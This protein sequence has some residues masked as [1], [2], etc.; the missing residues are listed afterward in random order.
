[1]RK[2]SA[3]IIY[4]ISQNPI[5]GAVI[6]INDEGVILEVLNDN[7]GLMDVEFFPGII[8]PGFINVHCHLELSHLKGLIEEKQGIVDF[9]LTVQKLR[10]LPIEEIEAAMLIA[11]QSMYEYGIVAVGDISNTSVSKKIKLES[12]IQYHTFIELLGFNPNNANQIL[13]KGLL[14]QNEFKTKT[15]ITAHAPYSVSSELFKNI[16]SLGGENLLS[17]HNQESDAENI[18]SM[19]ASGDFTKLFASFGIDI[20]YYKGN[21]Q[22]SL[23]SYLKYFS[24]HKIQLVHNTFSNIEDIQF[25]MNSNNELYWCLCPKANLYIESQ[26]PELLNLMENG[27][28]ITIGTDSLASNNSLDILDEIKCIQQFFPQITLDKLLTWA[29]LNGAEYLG[30]ANK[31]GSIETGKNPGLNLISHD[32]KTLQKII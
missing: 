5:E 19:N 2:I 16:S 27:C 12:K 25:G 23:P 29:T 22:R 26:L 7:E 10:E 11:D 28:K 15:S 9:I 24:H 6:I 3:D 8:C 14:I 17:I 21:N 32:L 13:E 4:P 18:F 31:L 30:L 1:M 20:S